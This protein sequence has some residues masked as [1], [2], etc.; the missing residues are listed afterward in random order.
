[1]CTI[2]EFPQTRHA[3]IEKAKEI[4]EKKRKQLTVEKPQPVQQAPIKQAAPLKL[5]LNVNGIPDLVKTL[6]TSNDTN[7]YLTDCFYDLTLS[8]YS[9]KK[10]V[11]VVGGMLAT[12]ATLLLVILILK[13]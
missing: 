4:T 10:A 8:I 7:K 5:S 1:M 11:L 6:E 3:R 12:L 2:I 13:G 9:L